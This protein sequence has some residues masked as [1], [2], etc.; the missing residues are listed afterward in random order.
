MFWFCV[1]LSSVLG[2]GGE[3][4][5]EQEVS[6]PAPIN[7][8]IVADLSDRLEDVAQSGR[9]IVVIRSA[10]DVLFNQHARRNYD[11]S[12]D[13]VRFQA[14]RA[15]TIANDIYL[16]MDELNSRS[17]EASGGQPGWKLVSSEAT[18]FIAHC[19][20]SYGAGPDKRGADLWGYFK[21]NYGPVI[22][23]KPFVNKVIVLTDGYLNFSDRIQ[24]QRPSNTQMQMAKLRLHP[25]DWEQE[26]PKLALAGVGKTFDADI[27][28]LEVAPVDALTHPQ[29][30][31]MLKRY[32]EA[33]ANSMGMRI[34]GKDGV[35]RVYLNTLQ[36][37]AVSQKIKEFLMEGV[38]EGE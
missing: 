14:V 37:S 1:V 29:E 3:N 32:W 38:P 5:S 9:D 20:E 15:N 17:S 34:K 25:A 13:L 33:W 10:V 16:D 7:L 36:M 2:C 4:V 6:E 21:D 26:L 11:T 22:R 23:P 28:V 19:E 35:A 27:M 30:P 31:E 12:K 18:K 24:R 8:V